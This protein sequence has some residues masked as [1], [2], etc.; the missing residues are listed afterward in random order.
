MRKACDGRTHP[1]LP[2]GVVV[3]L[4]ARAKRLG[5]SRDEYLRRLV[6]R[7]ATA[8]DLPVGVDDLERFRDRFGDLA[9][10]DVMRGAWR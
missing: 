4:D 7:A 5:L 8:I 2:D 1:G 10:P 6:M 9:D 3:A